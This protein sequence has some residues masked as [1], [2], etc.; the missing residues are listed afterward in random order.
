M[1][2]LKYYIPL[3]SSMTLPK[4]WKKESSSTEYDKKTP[5]Q[6]EQPTDD[7]YIADATIWKDVVT[8]FWGRKVVDA[9]YI[10]TTK[11]VRNGQSISH[12]LVDDI[13]V[14][15]PVMKYRSQNIE[16]D[17]NIPIDDLKRVSDRRVRGGKDGDR[18]CRLHL[19]GQALHH[20]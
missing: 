2:V 14:T 20:I 12:G 15:N 16:R 19:S 11:V 1:L 5:S 9:R 13:L 17:W 7:N 6:D 18:R 4:G 10:T 3:N 8:D